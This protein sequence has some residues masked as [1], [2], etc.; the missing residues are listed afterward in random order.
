MELKLEIFISLIYKWFCYGKFSDS[1][2]QNLYLSEIESA[3]LLDIF[4]LSL[5]TKLLIF[6]QLC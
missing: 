3:M 1:N 2:Q 6:P 5:T 4:I